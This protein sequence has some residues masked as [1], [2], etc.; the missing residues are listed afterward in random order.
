MRAVTRC[1]NLWAWLN[2]SK[3]K[4]WLKINKK[5]IKAILAINTFNEKVLKI[6]EKEISP[7]LFKI[8][9]KIITLTIAEIELAIA[10]PRCPKPK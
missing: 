1:K 5:D 3:L 9:L 6:P 7:S 4:Y 8:R 2:N 10:K